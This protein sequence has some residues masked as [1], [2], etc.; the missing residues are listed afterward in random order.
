MGALANESAWGA[1]SDTLQITYADGTPVIAG[2]GI[3]VDYKIGTAA[4]V[5]L[6]PGQTLGPID[7]PEPALESTGEGRLVVNID[8][9]LTINGTIMVGLG[10]KS[11]YLLEPPPPAVPTTFSDIMQCVT[12]QNP[13]NALHRDFEF[14]LISSPDPALNSANPLP[15]DLQLLETG[16]P[17]DLST[18]LFTATPG[19]PG[20]VTPPFH[21]FVTSDLDGVVPEPASLT[22]LALTSLAVLKPQRLNASKRRRIALP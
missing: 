13:S 19:S 1:P 11:A 22:L 6:Q 20:Q 10:S 4:T 9:Y 8:G 16:L 2:N 14:T 5:T 12:R 7:L 15:G 3:S 17:Q 21:V 18:G